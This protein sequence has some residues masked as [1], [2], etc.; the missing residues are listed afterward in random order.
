[1]RNT[2][3]AGLSKVDAQFL[4]ARRPVKSRTE[5]IKDS[6]LS[7]AYGKISCNSKEG[8]Q[9]KCGAAL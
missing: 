2:A 8:K 9:W 3:I 7:I 6:I 5:I 4:S 1:M